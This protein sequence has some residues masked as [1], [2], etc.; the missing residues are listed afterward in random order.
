MHETLTGPCFVLHKVLF[1]PRHVQ[2]FHRTVSVFLK[3]F[4]FGLFHISHK[5]LILLFNIFYTT[6][7]VIVCIS[8]KTFVYFAH[9]VTLL[10][11]YSTNPINF[12]ANFDHVLYGRLAPKVA[13]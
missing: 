1:G 9:P 7:I 3:T 5:K 2:E 10:L 8:H 13:L 6:L 12:Y 4:F 11:D